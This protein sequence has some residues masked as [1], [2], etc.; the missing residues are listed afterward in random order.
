VTSTTHDPLEALRVTL[1][2][3]FQAHTEH[4]TELTAYSRQRDHGGY[5]PDTLKGLMES[6]RQG[7]ADTAHAL[8][9]MSEGTYGRCE[10]CAGQIPVARL[11][12][13]PSARFCVPCQQKRSGA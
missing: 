1:E 5:D 4:L 10:G 12:L 3:Q 11:E 6:A 13:L 9:R 2:Q 8:R 7:I